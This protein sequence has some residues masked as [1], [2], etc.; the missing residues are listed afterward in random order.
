MQ[1]LSSAA[2]DPSTVPL[3][4]RALTAHL[5]AGRLSHEVSKTLEAHTTSVMIRNIPCG[6]KLDGAMQILDNFG[7]SGTYDFLYLP[8]NSTKKA[9]LGYLFVNFI[10]SVEATR[11]SKLLTGESV[12]SGLSIK[13]CEVSAAHIQGYSQMVAFFKQKAVLRSKSPPL[14][15]AEGVPLTSES[16]AGQNLVKDGGFVYRL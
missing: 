16:L 9:N 5:A 4:H 1:D 13:R 6:I 2:P 15:V 7:L 11:C 10:S 8:M 12:G 3:P 14:F